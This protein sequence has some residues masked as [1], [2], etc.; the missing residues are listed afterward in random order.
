MCRAIR[1]GSTH[2]GKDVVWETANVETRNSERRSQVRK[3]ICRIAL[4]AGALLFVVPTFSFAAEK[5]DDTHYRFDLN[6]AAYKGITFN[7]MYGSNLSKLHQG[8]RIGAFFDR[9]L[10]KLEDELKNTT[11]Q[12]YKDLILAV[13]GK[14]KPLIEF[15]NKE[16]LSTGSYPNLKDHPLSALFYT[17]LPH[18][19]HAAIKELVAK[20]KDVELAGLTI[21]CN[22]VHH[23]GKYMEFQKLMSSES[24]WRLMGP[25]E[26]SYFFTV[27]MDEVDNEMI[28]ITQQALD[29]GLFGMMQ[30]HRMAAD[31]D[32]EKTVAES[33][34]KAQT[35]SKVIELART[36]GC[37]CNMATQQCQTDGNPA[38]NCS[39]CGTPAKCCLGSFKCPV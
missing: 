28:E 31:A 4:V 13:E 37:C 29:V 1:W 3:G 8:I 5:Q 14:L 11:D 6:T 34:D 39:M 18:H 10:S 20:M 15:L 27:A 12:K 19:P 33:A 9:L 36:T 2:H 24:F 35:Y 7:E 26:Y 23:N 16:S 38:H 21:P 32:F 17:D 25:Q 22:L 30:Y